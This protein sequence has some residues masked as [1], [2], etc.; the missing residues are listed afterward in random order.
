MR[1]YNFRIN[2]LPEVQLAP[3]VRRLLL[4]IFQ[5]LFLLYLQP[6]SFIWKQREGKKCPSEKNLVE[7]KN[8]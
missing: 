3:I 1:N 6:V 2:Y 4:S 5:S 7:M 8:L